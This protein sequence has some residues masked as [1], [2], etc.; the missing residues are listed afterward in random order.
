MILI[1][2]DDLYWMSRL[3]GALFSLGFNCGEDEMEDWV[4]GECTR[5][6]V[7]A[8]QASAKLPETGWSSC[9]EIAISF[10]VY[11]PIHVRSE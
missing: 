6:A 3:H 8:F 4:F 9:V 11:F 5:E 7:F 1:D 10:Y 2:E